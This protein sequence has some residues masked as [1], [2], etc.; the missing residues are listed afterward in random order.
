MFSYAILCEEQPPVDSHLSVPSRSCCI[1]GISRFTL[2]KK[3]STPKERASA[4]QLSCD[5]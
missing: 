4:E 2:S 5:H 3:W 1:A